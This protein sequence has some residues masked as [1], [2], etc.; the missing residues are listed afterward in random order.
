MPLADQ[1][2]RAI[3][4]S[5]MSRYRICKVVGMSQA[6]MSR[7]MSGKGGLSVDM[8]DKLGDALDLRIAIGVETGGAKEGRTH[9]K[10]D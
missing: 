2:R 1:L 4:T 6:T 5:G 3:D 7:F 8:L 9:G 10:R